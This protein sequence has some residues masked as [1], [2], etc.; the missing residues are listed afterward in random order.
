MLCVCVCV[1]ELVGLFLDVYVSIRLFFWFL[2]M[3]MALYGN[4]HNNMFT[5]TTNKLS[6]S[7]CVVFMVHLSIWMIMAVVVVV[8]SFVHS[9]SF[10]L[11]FALLAHS[12]KIRFHGVKRWISQFKSTQVC[13]K[14]NDLFIFQ[15]FSTYLM[16]AVV[17]VVTPRISTSSYA[18]NI[19]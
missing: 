1:L 4:Q 17:V 9:F 11:F 5:W 13:F 6:L 18:H 16:V 2:M 14:R 19:L 15:R 10:T 8:S 3:M 7:V 12:L